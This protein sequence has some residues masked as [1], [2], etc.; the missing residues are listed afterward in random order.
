M[1]FFKA[2]FEKRGFVLVLLLCPTISVQQTEKRPSENRGFHFRSSVASHFSP[3]FS[4]DFASEFS[5][6]FTVKRMLPE[7]LT[8]LY[9]LYVPLWILYLLNI[10]SIVLTARSEPLCPQRDSYDRACSSHHHVDACI[11]SRLIYF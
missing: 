1:K 11:C 4:V 10:L 9:L 3:S 7:K 8:A 6:S 5:D 2:D